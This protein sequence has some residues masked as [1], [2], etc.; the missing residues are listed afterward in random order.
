MLKKI[1]FV[2]LGTVGFH[3]AANLAKSDY[4]LTVFDE[5]KK[6]VAELSQLGVAVGDT[7]AAT[8]KGKDLVI[9]IVPESK[10]LVF[11]EKG[12]L[13]GIDPGTIMVDMGTHCIETIE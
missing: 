7:P 1:G 10:F 4:E 12:V 5:D 2:G 11:G 13:E 8:A 6:A 9:V 3:M